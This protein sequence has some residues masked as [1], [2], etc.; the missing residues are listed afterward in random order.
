[1]TSH[2]GLFLFICAEEPGQQSK[3]LKGDVDSESRSSMESGPPVIISEALANFFGTNVREMLQ[4]EV[5]GRIW[6]YVKVNH[7]E[8][9]SHILV[10]F[11][12]FL[13]EF[14]IYCDI[15]SYSFFFFLVKS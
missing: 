10:S 11:F 14:A 13:S 5:L 15:T 2:L 7:L 3:R 8:V 4:S 9:G 1:M 12:W 6:K